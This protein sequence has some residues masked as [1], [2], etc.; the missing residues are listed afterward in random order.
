[1]DGLAVGRYPKTRWAVVAATFSDVRD[2]CAEGESGLVPILRRYNVLEATTAP[3]VNT[4]GQWKPNQ[5]IQ[6]C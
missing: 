5:V 2:T 3:S 4:I 1:M 6:C